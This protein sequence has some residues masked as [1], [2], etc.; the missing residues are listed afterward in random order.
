MVGLLL[1]S[2]ISWLQLGLQKKREDEFVFALVNLAYLLKH[3]S[4]N[5]YRINCGSHENSTIGDR[6]FLGDDYAFKYLATHGNVLANTSAN[7][8]LSLYQSARIFGGDA[9]Y[10][11]PLNDTGRYIIRLYFFPFTYKKYN[12]ST[13]KFSVSTHE[14]MLLSDYT[15]PPTETIKE[16]FVNISLNNLELI[17]TPTSNATLVN[18]TTAQTCIVCLAFETIAR[19]NIGGLTV[20]YNNDTLWRTWESDDNCVENKKFSKKYHKLAIVRYRDGLATRNAAP[21]GVYGTCRRVSTNDP[22]IVTWKFDVEAGFQYLIRFHYCDIFEVKNKMNFNIYVD[23]WLV[24]RTLDFT[25]LVHG[26]LGAPVYFDFVTPVINDNKVNISIGLSNKKERTC[27]A[28][29]NGLEIMKMNSDSSS[30]VGGLGTSSL[31]LFRKRSKNHIKVI[32]LASAAGVFLLVL[33]VIILIFLY[34]RRNQKLTSV[35]PTSEIS[36]TLPSNLGTRIPLT[37]VQE[38]TNNF[39]ES[40]V[41]GVGGFGRVFKGVLSDGTRIAVKRCTDLSN[42]GDNAFKTEIEMLSQ[43]RHRHLV[44]LIGYCDESSEMTLIYEYVENGTLQSHLY[45]SEKASLS[46]E[47]RLKICIGAAKGLLYLHTSLAESVIHRD[48]KSSNILLDENFNAK[49]SD[50]GLSK[51]APERS[52][53]TVSTGVKGTIG[54]IDPEYHWK[55]KLTKKSDVYSFGAVLF[56]VLCARTVVD[57]TLEEER[58]NLIEWALDLLKDGHLDQAVDPSI[59]GNIRSESLQIYV[60][61]AKLCVADRGVDRPSMKDVWL[62]LEHALKLQEQSSNVIGEIFEEA[63]TSAYPI[64]E[65]FSEVICTSEAG[66]AIARLDMGRRIDSKSVVGFYDVKILVEVDISL[67]LVEYSCEGISDANN[68][69]SGLDYA[70]GEVQYFIGVQ[71]DSSQCVERLQNSVIVA[72]VTETE[73][74]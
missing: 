67:E 74:L 32:L 5:S 1:D 35:P 27:D 11:F 12:L 46:W 22:T 63:S 42:Q 20:D 4:A 40:C 48:V 10:K 70:I 49:I 6:V 29:L 26:Y 61:T 25:T 60:E 17:F 15:P 73:H 13:I 55:N 18:P 2:P 31:P 58:I 23:S 43:F 52:L 9:R 44:S 37:I 38:A 68:C 56:E 8:N 57:P 47:Q 21:I 39:D 65:I 24:S 53:A 50:F 36:T 28:I 7:T 34:R 64:K 66:K 69:T 54:Y 3:I 33:A 16:Y 41:I 14:V 30:L 72:A 51:F 59:R 45:N 71:L 62:N 19:V